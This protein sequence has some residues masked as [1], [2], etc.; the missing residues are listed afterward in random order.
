MMSK[1]EILI[2]SQPDPFRRF[3][4]GFSL[5]AGIFSVISLFFCTLF[6]YFLS[7]FPF[8][9]ARRL[10]IDNALTSL[11]LSRRNIPADWWPYPRYTAKTKTPDGHESYYAYGVIEDF[12][13]IDKRSGLSIRLFSG[14]SNLYIISSSVRWGVMKNIYDHT[15]ESLTAKSKPRA[16]YSASGNKPLIYEITGSYQKNLYKNDIV[17][18]KW[19]VNNRGYREAFEI[20]ILGRK[21]AILR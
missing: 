12:T 17:M 4:F 13:R 14:E 2:K 15:V 19:S 5:I 18:I 6:W 3:F 20:N 9:Y 11:R 16:L 8:P 7:Y 21:V 1:S 10:V